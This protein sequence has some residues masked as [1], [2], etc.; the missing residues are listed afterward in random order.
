MY[1]LIMS[2]LSCKHY[3]YVSTIMPYYIIHTTIIM[4]SPLCNSLL[5]C[6]TIMHYFIMH[7]L[8]CPTIMHYYDV[9]YHHALLSCNHFTM[10]TS[11]MHYYMH[12]YHAL[13]Y[14]APTIMHYYRLLSCPIMHHYHVTTI[15]HYYHA[16]LSCTTIMHY[17]HA[18]IMHYYH[19]LLSCTTIMRIPH[20]HYHRAPPHHVALLHTTVPL[21][22]NTILPTDRYDNQ[23]QPQHVLPV[24]QN[25]SKS[26]IFPVTVEKQLGWRVSFERYFRLSLFGSRYQTW[27]ASKPP[28]LIN[29]PVT[30]QPRRQGQAR[31]GPGPGQGQARPGPG[32]GKIGPGQARAQAQAQAQAQGPGPRPRPR[33]Q[34]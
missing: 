34:V 26:S 21:H 16:L 9:V 29:P 19:A 6:T 25:N 22:H 32:Q 27:D 15:M 1:P 13:I 2:L 3:Y 11:I 20:M 17:Y 4:H 18:L 30:A 8:S 31:P 14:H 24:F 7:S 5:S 23:T 12:Y 28:S 33:A 10:Y